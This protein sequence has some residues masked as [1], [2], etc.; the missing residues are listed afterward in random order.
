MAIYFMLKGSDC[1]SLYQQILFDS[2]ICDIIFK[3]FLKYEENEPIVLACCKAVVT[4]ANENTAITQRLGAVGICN[5]IVEI[6][7]IY[8]SSAKV[9]A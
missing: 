9:G 7:Q 4:L 8:P 2:G 6:M 1:D 3:L 5:Q